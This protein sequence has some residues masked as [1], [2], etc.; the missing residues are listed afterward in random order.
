MPTTSTNTRTINRLRGDLYTAEVVEKWIDRIKKRRDYLHLFDILGFKEG[1]GII[2]IQTTTEPQ[3]YDHRKAML[4]NA[5]LL[6]WLMSG[7]RG[8][9]WDWKA[10]YKGKRKYW[11]PRIQEATV[12]DGVVIFET[13][14]NGH[15]AFLENKNDATIL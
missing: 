2:G 15:R 13:R 1:E 11:M 14:F 5:N 9:L 3:M 8:E 6:P 4:A 10:V 12:I 7:G